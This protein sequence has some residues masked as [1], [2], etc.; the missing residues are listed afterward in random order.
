MH[1]FPKLVEM[2]FI[3]TMCGTIYLLCYL[4]IMRHAMMPIELLNCTFTVNRS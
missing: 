1:V 3:W 2:Y 4:S